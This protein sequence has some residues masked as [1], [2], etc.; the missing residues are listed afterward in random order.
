MFFDTDLV[1]YPLGVIQ[2]GRCWSCNWDLNEGE[3]IGRRK[4][5][6]L[7]SVKLTTFT[8]KTIDEQLQVWGFHPPHCYHVNFNSPLPQA[9]TNPAQN[10]YLWGIRERIE[11]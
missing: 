4:L 5:A 10:V 1:Q 8:L 9:I 11:R 3:K 6:V 2:R 7:P